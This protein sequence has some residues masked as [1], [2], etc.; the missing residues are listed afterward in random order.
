MLIKD[1]TVA[2]GSTGLTATITCGFQPDEI[3]FY[4]SG[5]FSGGDTEC[6]FSQGKYLA[7]ATIPQHVDST[8]S[9]GTS[10]T[11]ISDDTKVLNHLE[12]N[13]SGIVS[14]IVGTVASVSATGYKLNLSQASSAYN[15]YFVARKY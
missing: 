9:N 4:V 14:V 2:F 7:G 12:D 13:G 8:F 5:L 3:D 6:H 15:I 11:S 10:S 1:G